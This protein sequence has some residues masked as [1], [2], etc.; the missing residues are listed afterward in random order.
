M[1]DQKPDPVI[2]SFFTNQNIEFEEHAMHQYMVDIPTALNFEIKYSMHMNSIRF[3]FIFQIVG[4]SLP[5]D[6]YVTSLERCHAATVF[7]NWLFKA[8]TTIEH[9]EDELDRL[10]SAGLF[11]KQT[12]QL[13]CMVMGYPPNGMSRM[14]TLD[15]Y[16]GRGYARLAIHYI[17]KRMAQCGL[18]PF[19]N[20]NTKNVNSV[21]CFQGAG[22]RN[23]RMVSVLLKYPSAALG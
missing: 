7:N 14:F 8:T 4:L 10:P 2:H 12:D 18:V 20:I 15:E 23:Y 3:T 17:S 19:G 13:V 6:V 9:V 21:K 22:F 16:R 5:D 1:R 11:L